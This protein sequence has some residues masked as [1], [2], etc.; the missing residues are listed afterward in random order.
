MKT[1]RAGLLLMLGSIAAIIF[2]CSGAPGDADDVVDRL[3]GAYGGPEKIELMKSFIG[4]GFMKDQ[5]NQSV[6]RYWPY[7]HFQRDTMLKTKVALTDKGIAY[8]I[9]FATFDGLNYRVAEKNGDMNYPPVAELVRID[10]RFPLILDWLR[11]SGLEG[12]LEDNGDEGGVCRVV[13]VDTYDLVEVGVDRESWLLRYVRFESRTDSTK[14]FTETYS[15]Y[16]EVDGVPFPS[17][18]TGT[19]TNNRPYYEYYFVKVEL[20][21]ELPDSTFIISERE[22]A[23]IP[24]SGTGPATQ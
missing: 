18:F 8:N 24:K 13:Y 6:I 1:G 7:D 5:L 16:W 3:I 11:N 23:L 22:L 19:F 15:D 2:S 14:I 4:K 17:R 21:A 20:G 9:R 12:R 10:R